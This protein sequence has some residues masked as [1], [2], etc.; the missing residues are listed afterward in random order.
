MLYRRCADDE[1]DDGRRRRTGRCSRK[2][3]EFAD[4]Q[5]SSEHKRVGFVGRQLGPR[6]DLRD[7]LVQ[8]MAGGAELEELTHETEQQLGPTG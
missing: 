2:V 3:L 7:A 8:T 1:R 6:R 5:P 4:D